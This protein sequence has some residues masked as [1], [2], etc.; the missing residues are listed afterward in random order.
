[1]PQSRQPVT[2]AR[3][4]HLFLVIEPAEVG[5][6]WRFGEL[7][8]YAGGDRIITIGEVTPGAFV[9]PAGRV[10]VTPRGTL[11]HSELIVTHGP[12]SFMGEPAQ[13]S[14]RPSSIAFESKGSWNADPVHLV[15][16]Q[17]QHAR[18]PSHKMRLLP[19]W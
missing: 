5:R 19:A 4:D 18:T 12:S 13:T 14:G 6:L 10:E 2:E 9:I 17:G 3:R 1:M 11:E 16:R 7:K 8:S 15:R